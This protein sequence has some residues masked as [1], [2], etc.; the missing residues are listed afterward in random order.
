MCGV[1]ASG[2]VLGIDV[3]VGQ[4]V[5]TGEPVA[6]MGSEG[7]NKRIL[8]LEIRRN[9]QPINP[10]PWLAVRKGNISG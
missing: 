1:T 5:L 3:G 9:S 2:D 4:W 10:L 6:V 7:P 8:Y